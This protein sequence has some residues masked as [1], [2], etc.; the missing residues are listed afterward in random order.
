MKAPPCLPEAEI[1]WATAAYRA[2]LAREGLPEPVAW[3]AEQMLA[4]SRPPNWALEWSL[5]WWLGKALGLRTEQARSL[6]LANVLGLTYIR[7]QD[8]LADGAVG[9]EMQVPARLLG[10]ALLHMWLSCYMD[11]CGVA[12]AFWRS[13]DSYLQQ[14][15][16]AAW[17][18]YEPVQYFDIADRADLLAL[19]QRGAPLK[20]CAAAACLLADRPNKLVMLETMLDDLLVAAVLLDHAQDWAED[21]A[22]G[23]WNAFMAQI[24]GT[25]ALQDL[26]HGRRAVM[27]ELAVGAAGRPYFA[28]IHQH[29]CFAL[30]LADEVGLGALAGYI[31]WLEDAAGA[32]RSKWARAARQQLRTA[33][34]ALLSDTT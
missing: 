6:V 34:A 5:P 33:T 15:L 4:R 1:D 24:T 18:S 27:Q 9:S 16:A 17:R 32:L 12:P 30:G 28:V 21:A 22:A 10:T 31:G 7:L 3:L 29:L 11:L 13:F 23:R 8:D 25:C 2:L 26:A 20:S 19:A 14:W